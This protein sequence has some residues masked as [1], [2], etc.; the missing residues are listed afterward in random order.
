MILPLLALLLAVA[1]PSASGIA[2]AVLITGG[3][4]NPITSLAKAE[5]F[6]KQVNAL[7]ALAL[8]AAGGAIAVAVTGGFAGLATPQNWMA[9]ASMTYA[10][11][12]LVYYGLFKDT[13]LDDVFSTLGPKK[14][15]IDPQPA[16]PA[17]EHERPCRK[18]GS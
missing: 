15:P 13:K 2:L 12:Q 14:H 4:L 17:P 8:S 5:R 1:Q 6:P 11:S 10:A 18:Q 16:P 9:I 7:I 3:L